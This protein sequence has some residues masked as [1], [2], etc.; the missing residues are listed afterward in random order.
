MPGLLHAPRAQPEIN[1]TPLIDVL[2]VLLAVFFLINLLQLRLVQDVQV[3]PVA[4]A[5]TDTEPQIVLEL[6]PLQIYLERV[7]EHRP[8]GLL[9]VRADTAHRYQEVV[10][11]LDVARAAGIR[12]VAFLPEASN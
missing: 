11:A 10:D 12:T 5:T 2:L 8:S 9:F 7:Y 6:L 1:V 3:P 4:S